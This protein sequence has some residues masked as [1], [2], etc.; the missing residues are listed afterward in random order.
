MNFTFLAFLQFKL[1]PKP[2]ERNLSE[3][4]SQYE[5]AV[6]AAYRV[7]FRQCAKRPNMRRPAESEHVLASNHIF[8]TLASLSSEGVQELEVL[9]CWHGFNEPAL[10]ERP[11]SEDAESASGHIVNFTPADADSF[12]NYTANVSSADIGTA[13][14]CIEPVTSENLFGRDTLCCSYL[15]AIDPKLFTQERSEERSRALA[16]PENPNNSQHVVRP[17]VELVLQTRAEEE[18]DDEDDEEEEDDDDIDEEDEDGAT[19]EEPAAD[20]RS[21]TSGRGRE[22]DSGTNVNDNV[23]G[24]DSDGTIRQSEDIVALRQSA[25]RRRSREHN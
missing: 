17:H 16:A 7:E 4:Q 14:R 6:K 13:L 24:N 5:V 23:R 19:E 10:V 18:D 1:S 8:Y 12:P 2:L 15:L 3:E 11:G 22:T 20:L 9:D 21:D 25:R